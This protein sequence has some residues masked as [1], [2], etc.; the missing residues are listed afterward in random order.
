MYSDMFIVQI[1]DKDVIG[2]DNLIGEA[3]INLNTMHKIIQK[4]VARKKTVV[5]SKKIIE[6]NMRLTDKFWIDVVNHR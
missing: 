5:A 1:W 6:K 3:R 4:A 2:F